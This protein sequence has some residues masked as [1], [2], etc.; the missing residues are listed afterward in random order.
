M[1]TLA[2]EIVRPYGTLP[3]D[4]RARVLVNRLWPRGVRRS[5]LEP[6][7]WMQD[8]APSTEL[9]RWYGHDPKRA[10][11]FRSRY[12]TELETSPARECLVRLRSLATEP[13]LILITATREVELSEAWV[14]RELLLKRVSKR[15][16]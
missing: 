5:A 8:V 3:D 2:V 14:L 15:P 12:R 1:A 13:G 9:R 10:D 16:R 4:G 6:F 11:E 7:E